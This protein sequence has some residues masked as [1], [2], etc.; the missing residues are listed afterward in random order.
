MAHHGQGYGG[1][2]LVRSGEPGKDIL[3][4]TKKDDLIGFHI[5]CG[6]GIRNH[7]GLWRGNE[8]LLEDACGKGCNPDNASGV[9]IEAVW[10]AVQDKKAGKPLAVPGR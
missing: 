10:Q 8:G 3:R 6:M 2:L 1:D 4:Q 5:G 7:Y 9:I